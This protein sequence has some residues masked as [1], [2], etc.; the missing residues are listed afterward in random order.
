MNGLTCGAAMGP[1]PPTTTARPSDVPAV[2]R[3]PPKGPLRLEAP[4]DSGLRYD[5]LNFTA[6]HGVRL[7]TDDLLAR[8]T[9]V[10]LLRRSPADRHAVPLPFMG[11]R[12]SAPA[13]S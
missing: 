13:G 10:G 5:D 1:P 9:L 8:R 4:R 2:P 3:P 6:L 12:G 11:A 7:F